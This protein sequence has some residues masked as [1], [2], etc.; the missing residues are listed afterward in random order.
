VE[1]LFHQ[2]QVTE[3]NRWKSS[4]DES[5]RRGQARSLWDG[6]RRRD[7]AG[8]GWSMEEDGHH[9]SRSVSAVGGGGGWLLRA[10]SDE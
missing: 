9:E 7:V 2:G 6:S 5:R 1:L 10:P 8:R 3:P 4:W